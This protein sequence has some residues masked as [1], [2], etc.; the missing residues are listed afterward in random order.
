M[1][2]RN[3][4][5]AT[6]EEWSPI[7]SLAAAGLFFILA[8]NSGF[9]AATGAGIA[10]PPKIIWACLLVVFLGVL[11]LYPRLAERDSTLA[12][13]GVGFLAVTASVILSNFSLS[14]LPLGLTLGKPT[15]VAIIMS[16]VVGSTLTLTMFGVASL[17]TGAHPCPVGGSL[18]VMAAGTLF[19]TVTM[20]VYSN[21]NPAWV[22]LVVNGLFATSL[23][24]IGY[25]LR[26]ADAQADHAESTGDVIIN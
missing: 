26:T 23:G 17:R 3:T 9:R 22:G 8:A 5:L 19:I 12:R 2:Y 11:G 18:L 20:V 6:F 13:G 10:V 1:S 4:A 15:I 16:V 21:P 7:T 25:V 14:V 24:S